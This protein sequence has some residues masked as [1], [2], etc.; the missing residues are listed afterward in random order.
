MATLFI[1][2]GHL[3]REAYKQKKTAST[4]PHGLLH[5]TSAKLKAECLKKCTNAVSK[6]D[7]KVI[8]DFCEDLNESKTCH[9]LLQRCD[10][11]KFKP[12]VYYLKEKSGSTD[13]KNI[14][15]LAWLLDFP[16]RPWE[17]GKVYPVTEDTIEKEEMEEKP[18]K[19]T[20]STAKEAK[21]TGVKPVTINITDKLKGK[22]TKT[23]AAAVM[24][25]LALGT[26]SMWWLKGSQSPGSN[27]CMYWKEDH[28]ER[29]ACDQ[30]VSD[31]MVIA[32]DE[33]KL[34]HFRKISRPD[35]I[36]YNAIGRIWYSKIDGKIEYYTAGG[37]HP[38]AFDHRLKP[39]SKYIIDKYIATGTITRE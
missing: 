23:M 38:V 20:G 29:I 13:Q 18:E 31:A 28:Y 1:E 39:I 34:K 33:M 19:G 36:T 16:G 5:L 24:L 9:M 6:R 25:S 30:K 10:T 22:S 15:L 21:P 11:D 35:T 3:V 2:Y 14:E 8:R 12:L 17:L 27:G 37:E 7:E 26:G 4:L 32:L